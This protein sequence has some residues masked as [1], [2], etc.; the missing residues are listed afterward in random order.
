MQKIHSEFAGQ[1]DWTELLEEFLAVIPQRIAGI[2]SALK[3]EDVQSLTYL[4]H[5]LRGSCGS[6]GFGTLTPLA[7]EIELNLKAGKDLKALDQS[8]Q[9]FLEALDCMTAAPECAGS[10]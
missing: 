4:V 8:I 6:Y 5:Q 7:T 9:S 3:S 2:E 1:E 10:K